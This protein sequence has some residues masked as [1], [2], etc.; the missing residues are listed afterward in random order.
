MLV[1]QS[2][3]LRIGRALNLEEGNKLNCTV[4][5]LKE[6]PAVVCIPSRG[7]WFGSCPD[8]RSLPSLFR[9]YIGT[10]SVC[11]GKKHW[12]L[13]RLVTAECLSN[14]KQGLS[15]EW[16][17]IIPA[18]LTLQKPP[19]PLCKYH[20]NVL[21]QGLGVYAWEGTIRYRFTHLLPSRVGFQIDPILHL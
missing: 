13:H 18:L 8:Q 14:P 1:E 11:E 9:W 2:L 15:D 17:T 16:F 4:A 3:V 20:R 12:R 10:R 5:Q 7:S 19:P 6:A 21:G